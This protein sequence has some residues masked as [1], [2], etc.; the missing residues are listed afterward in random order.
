MSKPALI[1]D[2]DGTLVDSEKRHFECWR[3][4]LGRHGIDLTEAEYIQ[5]YNGIPTAQNAATMIE[6]YGLEICPENL[7]HTK[8]SLFKNQSLLTPNP[9]MPT[10]KVT[11]ESAKQQGYKMAIATGAGASDISRSMSAHSLTPYFNAIATRSDVQHGKPAPDV[12]LLACE[13]LK[14][15][16]INAVAFE[17]TS[18]GIAAAKAAGLYCIAIPNDYSKQQ[19]L[20]EADTQSQTLS[21]AFEHV[22]NVISV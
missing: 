16:P 5:H 15:S 18:A 19:D 8:Q 12:Y 20:S 2:H 3:S 10:V 9:L 1:F 14:T 17:D 13:L 6:S 4:V 7:S 11:L 21:K 22:R